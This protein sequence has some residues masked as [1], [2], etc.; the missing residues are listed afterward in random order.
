MTD[1][2]MTADL[3]APIRVLIADDEVHL[4]TILE[5]YLS[6]RGFAVT[7]VRDGREAL[8]RLLAER[9]DEMRR[10]LA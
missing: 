10:A 4:G 9:F 5:Q 6:A 7:V 2:T 3:V 8:D 1:A